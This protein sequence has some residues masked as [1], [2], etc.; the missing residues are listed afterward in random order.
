ME[1]REVEKKYIP[2]RFEK[3]IRTQPEPRRPS[4]GGLRRFVQDAI[5]LVMFVVQAKRGGFWVEEAV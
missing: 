1:T 3:H 4:L 5:L 2:W